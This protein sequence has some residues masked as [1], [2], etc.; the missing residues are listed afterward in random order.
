MRCAPG[1]KKF[2]KEVVFYWGDFSFFQDFF[3]NG[4]Y[5]FLQTSYTQRTNFYAKIQLITLLEEKCNSFLRVPFRQCIRFCH[6]NTITENYMCCKSFKFKG[7][8]SKKDGFYWNNFS[9]F[10]WI[11][12][13][14][15]IAIVSAL[16]MWFN[17]FQFNFCPGKFFISQKT[18]SYEVSFQS[19]TNEWKKWLNRKNW[20]LRCRNESNEASFPG[21]RILDKKWINSFFRGYC[22]SFESSQILVGQLFS[23][24]Y[25]DTYV[26][27]TYILSLDVN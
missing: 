1:I 3:W 25:V 13:Q 15:A 20:I 5:Q 2:C 8:T 24:W 4:P 18:F 23:F 11:L 10:W 21:L 9:F 19:Q 27:T 6:L 14:M 26:L 22:Y 7:N 17:N 12:S 16:F